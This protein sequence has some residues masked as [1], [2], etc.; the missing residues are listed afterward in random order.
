[1]KEAT[2]RSAGRPIELL[3]RVDLADPAAGHHRDTIRQRQRLA[4]VVGDEDGGDAELALDLLDLDLH[5]GAQ[6]LVERRERLVEQQHL[7][8]DDAAPAQA[9]R[10]AAARRTTAAACGSAKPVSLISASASATRRAISA[11]GTPRAFRP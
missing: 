9:R 7:R 10:A 3:G 6:I 2:K 4:L 5:R 1:M 11:F 8:L